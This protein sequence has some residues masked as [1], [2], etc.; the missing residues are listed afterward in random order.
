MP[1][2]MTKVVFDTP[3]DPPDGGVYSFPGGIADALER[4][5]VAAGDKVI[6]V[7]GGAQTGQQFLAA[8][9]VDEL[10]LHVVPILLGA[11]TRM[12]ENVADHHVSLEPLRTIQTPNA[13]HLRLRVVRSTGAA[14]A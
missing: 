6:T 10:S 11:G 13:T 14:A 3:P 12:F 2:A 9:L 8:G 5:R 4:A 1:D 7:M